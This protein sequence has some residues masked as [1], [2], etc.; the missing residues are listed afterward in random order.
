MEVVLDA[1]VFFRILIS[2]GDILDFIFKEGLHLFAPLKLKEEFLKHKEEILLK[3]KLSEDEF[4]VLSSLIFNKISFSPLEEYK[5]SLPKAKSLL[6]E[7]TKDE[8]FVALCLSK[9]IKLWTVNK[10]KKL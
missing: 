3:S 1:N 7:H 4:N 8:D 6:K 5:S 2:Q 9:D 10:S